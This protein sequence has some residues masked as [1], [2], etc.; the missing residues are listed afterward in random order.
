[1]QAEIAEEEAAKVMKDQSL[2]DENELLKRELEQYRRHAGA[3]GDDFMREI[4]H[5]SNR[6]RILE[7]DIHDKDEALYEEKDKADKLS[8]KVGE[9]EKDI[10]NLKRELERSRMDGRDLQRQI[11]QQ[12]ETL[13]MR[14][15]G[16]GDIK[17]T[18]AKKNKEL[19]EYLDEIKLLQE[20]NEALGEQFR[21][22]KKELQE[23]AAEMDKM[24]DEYTKLK[25]ILQQ[26]DLILDEMRRERD[27]LRA[28]VQDLRV[29]V[30]TKTDADDQIMMA[31]NLKVE[32]WKAVLAKK[33]AEIEQHKGIISELRQ[34][35]TGLEMDSDRSSMAMLQQALMEK[36]EQ[37]QMLRQELEKASVE[38]KGV[39]EQVE[40][41]KAQAGKGVPSA[42][43][44]K[45]IAELG[46]TLKREQ[47]L[48]AQ[49]RE[50]LT[51]AEEAA[52]RKDKQLNDLMARMM[53]YE[54]GEYG[55][56]E[57]V[58]EIKESKAQ[59]RIRDEN[60]ENLTNQVNKLDLYANDLEMENE[61]LRE[62][63]GMDPRDKLDMEDIRQK[64]KVKAEQ[65]SAMN[66]VL[67]KEIERLE[68][69]RLRLKKQLRK[70]AMHRGARA[71]EL[72][73]T[74]EDLADVEDEPERVVFRKR[75]IDD[76]DTEEARTRNKRLEKDIEKRDK[77]SDKIKTE[78][79]R[80]EAE[81]KELKDEN[82]QLE[83][84]L[85]EI[86]AQLRE[87]AEQNAATMNRD[88][89]QQ[90]QQQEQQQQQQQQQQ[91]EQQQQQQQPLKIQVPALEKLMA[92]ALDDSVSGKD[93]E[94]ANKQYNELTAKYR[95]L[96]QREN[97]LVSRSAIVE[98]LEAEVKVLQDRETELK[99]D[100]TSLKEKNY[101]MEQML[102]ELIAKD[103]KSVGD[104]SPAR[105][106]E[107]NR[108]SRKLATLEMKELNE[109]E[110]AD[111]STRKYTQ[112]KKVFDEL[113][114][115]N[116]ELEQKF[117]EI[118]KL[119]FEAQR[120]ERHLREELEGAV[121]RNMH[122]SVVKRLQSCEESEASLKIEVSRLKE[123]AEV[124][125]HQAE[126]VRAH[127]EGQEKE[128]MALRTQ[129][130][131]V[132]MESDEKTIIGKYI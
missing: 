47:I 73:I 92:Q 9:M 72:G 95:D 64:K 24:T 35:V 96:L 82:K 122:E 110:R 111:H 79:K 70:Q 112:L 106:E 26:S 25:L 114:Q 94:N 6:N 101:S 117:G 77:E 113:E 118:G 8:V 105:K 52:K 78:V 13:A 81:N 31:V 51:Q 116:A 120:I 61:E 20:E 74:A 12:R 21:N 84:G 23:S 29:Q 43:Q 76:S 93:L 102:N 68:D 98:T 75:I 126:A 37:I 17:S 10:R 83:I 44:Q 65:A 32:E 86:L 59:I 128:L 3:G 121:T 63:L 18:V 60:I 67:V 66:R 99:K 130:Y 89:Q 50:R 48:S 87:T 27:A 71:V 97:T 131:D 125:A 123:I 62:R 14:R 56:S 30:S 85:R 127:Q 46:S 107:I 55:L 53:Q 109:R 39:T 88:P 91:Q 19:S 69:E 38:M 49:E 41:V 7:Q 132:Q 5:L 40:E 108:I 1:M 33:E 36:D 42:Y 115:R 103:D 16:D 100:M 119:N 11:E 104:S 45:K 2:I 80:I 90:E 15:G 129:L 54:K 57:A 28:Q 124:A 34:R 4:Q 58:Q 22:V